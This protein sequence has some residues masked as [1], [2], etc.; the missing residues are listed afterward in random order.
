MQAS[1]EEHGAIISSNG[2][3]SVKVEGARDHQSMPSYPETSIEG[4]AH[5][6]HFNEPLITSETSKDEVIKIITRQ[7][8]NVS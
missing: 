5:F 2:R 7:M 3:N 6:I 4:I 8:S 1:I